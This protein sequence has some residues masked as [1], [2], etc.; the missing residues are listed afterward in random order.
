M[1]AKPTASTQSQRCTLIRCGRRPISTH[2]C[3]PVCSRG[4]VKTSYTLSIVTRRIL[5]S[6]ASRGFSSRIW[7]FV[8]TSRGGGRLSEEKLQSAERKNGCGEAGRAG[9]EAQRRRAMR[10]VKLCQRASQ[11]FSS[12]IW[13]FLKTSRGMISCQRSSCRELSLQAGCQGRTVAA[14]EERGTACCN[15]PGSTMLQERKPRLC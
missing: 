4:V 2:T 13:R 9:G 11:G 3:S 8:K 6:R 1:Q 5:E 12:R 7:G 15:M 14:E 10:H